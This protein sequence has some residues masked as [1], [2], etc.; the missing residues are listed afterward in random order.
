MEQ[1]TLFEKRCECGAAVDVV[2]MTIDGEEHYC[3]ACYS[4]QTEEKGAS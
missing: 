1:L 4:E 3:H 2:Q